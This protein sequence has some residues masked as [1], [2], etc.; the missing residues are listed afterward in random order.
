MDGSPRAPNDLV[1]F[2]G[3]WSA[4]DRKLIT[5]AVETVENTSLSQVRRPHRAPWIASRHKTEEVEL[6]LASRFG[7]S[8]V[9]RAHSAED[10][11]RKIRRFT[12]TDHADE[13]DGPRSTIGSHIPAETKG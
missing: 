10:L 1:D 4:S 9:F 5:T 8:D 11:A 6:Y 3:P 2:S 7:F 13:G 12:L